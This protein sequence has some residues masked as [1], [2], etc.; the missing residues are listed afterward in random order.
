MTRPHSEVPEENMRYGL[1]FWMAQ[2]G[3]TVTLVGGDAG[4]S[5]YSAHDPTTRSTWTVVSNTTDG[6]WPVVRHLVDV[7]GH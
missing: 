2:T 6:A 3:P 1:G 5:F 4:V 7:L